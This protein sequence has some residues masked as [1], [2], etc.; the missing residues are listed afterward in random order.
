VVEIIDLVTDVLQIA[1]GLYIV[2][3]CVRVVN[4]V[5]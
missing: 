4:R 1:L 5:E 3:L 2:T